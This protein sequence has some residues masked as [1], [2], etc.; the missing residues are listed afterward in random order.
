MGRA[1]SVQV[2]VKQQ[3]IQVLSQMSLSVYL[4]LS[5]GCHE[6]GVLLITGLKVKFGH[7]S[8]QMEHNGI[9]L[10][11]AQKTQPHFIAMYFNWITSVI[12]YKHVMV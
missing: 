2:N 11:H 3:N 7:S 1:S 12:G 4:S 9:E 8:N 5:A 6:L 10:T